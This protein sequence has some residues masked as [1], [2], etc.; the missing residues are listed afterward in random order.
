MKKDISIFCEKV[1]KYTATT[2]GK[3]A[4]KSKEFIVHAMKVKLAPYA[5]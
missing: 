2:K 3:T 4:F 5:L 1:N